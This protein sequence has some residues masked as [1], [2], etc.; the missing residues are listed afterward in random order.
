MDITANSVA[1]NV[2]DNFLPQ[3]QFE[4]VRDS[5]MYHF[6]FPWY[7]HKRVNT[8]G[9]NCTEEYWNWYAT[10]T[11]YRNDYAT[12]QQCH[13]IYDIFIPR[14]VEMNIYH[15]LLRIKGNFYP[16][17]ETLKEHAVHRDYLY[18]NTGALYSL[19]TCDG[20]TKL[21]DGTKIPSVANR[22]LIFDSSIIHN[23]T[24]TTNAAGR[25]NIN[26]NFL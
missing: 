26:F 2:I 19:N 20:Y 6:D 16:H 1:Y 9:K 7:I 4:E 24:T 14:F 8:V 13:R 18:S 11:F 12:S 15:S 3:E 5:I 22:I 21:C 10:H 23:S 25:F 17:T